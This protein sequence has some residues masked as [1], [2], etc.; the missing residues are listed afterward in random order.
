TQRNKRELLWEA[1]M[2]INKVTFEE[3]KLILFKAEKVNYKT[4]NLPNTQLEDAFDEIELL[5]YPLC[6]PFELL[7]E[8]PTGNLRAR[9]LQHFIEKYI[10]ID[11]YLVTTKNTTTANGKR[12]HFGTFLDQ[13]GDFIDTVHFPPVASKYRFRGKGVY[14][15][16]GKVMEEFD[17]VTIEV[18]KMERLP[19]IEDPRY[20]EGSVTTRMHGKRYKNVE[21]HKVQ[22][23]KS[24]VGRTKVEVEH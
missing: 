1:H 21:K 18:S 22:T 19:I 12:M 13:D 8:P 10:A 15:I 20:A 24:K 2:K 14:R 17:C 7:T 5:G 4:P 16:T 3:N 9:H 6:N 23:P 11:G